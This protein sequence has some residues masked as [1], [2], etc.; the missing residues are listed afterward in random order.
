MFT[1]WDSNNQLKAYAVT[2][3]GADLTGCIHEWGGDLPNV[4][5]LISEMYRSE[6]RNYSLMTSRHTKN[7]NQR[8][9]ELGVQRRDGFLGM[10][11]MLDTQNLFFKIHRYARQIGIDNLVLE[12]GDDDYFYLG[13][14][15]N[16]FRTSS[17]RDFTKIIFGPAEMPHIDGIDEQTKNILAKLLPLP[18]WIWG[19]D[20]I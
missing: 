2:G 12:R 8:L 6:Q 19:W 17:E 1:A 4:L 11:K 15:E 10:I 18:M 20:S 7:L 13:I 5:A 14:G 3:R 9:T 16:V